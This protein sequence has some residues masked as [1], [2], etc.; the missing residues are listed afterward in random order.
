MKTVHTVFGMTI[1]V[2][3]DEA[4]MLERQGLLRDT[5]AADDAVDDTVTVTPKFTGTPMEMPR[6]EADQLRK[7]GLLIDD[8]A[9]PAP[10]EDEN[11][12]EGE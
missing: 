2:P 6:R 10:S 12:K 8:S 9:P 4:V 7:D 1:D 3:D 5:P 11:S